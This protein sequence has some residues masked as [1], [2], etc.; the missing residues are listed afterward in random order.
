MAGIGPI[1]LSNWLK[2]QKSSL[3]P[4]VGWKYYL[5]GRSVPYRTPNVFLKIRME[6][7]FNWQKCYIGPLM[8][9]VNQK[10]IRTLKVKMKN[11]SSLKL[12]I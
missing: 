2:F 5:I 6:M 11:K 9:F 8:F 10:S 1:M 12:E 7:L 4:H 3:K